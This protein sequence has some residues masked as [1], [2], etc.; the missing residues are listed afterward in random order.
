[1]PEPQEQGSSRDENEEQDN[2]NNSSEAAIYQGKT[3]VKQA[4]RPKPKDALKLTPVSVKQINNVIRE[5]KLVHEKNK[6]K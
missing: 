3:F 4:Q 1:L 6:N 5:K 2:S